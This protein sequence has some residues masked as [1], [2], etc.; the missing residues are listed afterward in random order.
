MARVAAELREIVGGLDPACVD[1]HEALGLVRVAADL[2]RLGATAKA[3]LAQRCVD[4]GVWKTD[5]SARVPATTPAEWLADVSGSGIGPA[6][7]ALAVSEALSECPRTDAALRSGELSL[8]T[9]REVTAAAAIGG[10]SA[11]QRVLRSAT[12]DGLRGARDESRRVL[13]TA[14]DAEARAAKIDRD[15]SR[16]R[17]ITREG[18]WNLH[19]EGPVSLGAEIEACLAPFDDA[20]WDIAA[21]QPGH[22]RDTPNAIAFDGLVLM[23][24]ASRDGAA[25]AS[26]KPRGRAKTRPHVVA[27]VDATSLVSGVAGPGERCEIAGVGPV[28]IAHVRKLLGDAMLTILVED[29]RDV[30]TFARPGRRVV[31]ALA[32]LL[33]ARDATCIISGCG[34]AARLEADHH[35][36]VSAGG[37]SDHENLHGL[38]RQHHRLKSNGWGLEEHAD[39]TWT[40]DPPAGGATSRQPDAA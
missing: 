28:P 40:L 18:I 26:G 31:A 39:G 19:L 14:A 15:R 10:E 30:R 5:R 32:Q 13:A 8:S 24:R 29:G 12:R 22:A 4:T 16:R 17:W 7:D 27:H 11:E 38:C 21:K 25:P 2:E 9:A 33:E 1:G 3:L 6:K 34:R 20:A 36:P 37:D 23:A 35:R